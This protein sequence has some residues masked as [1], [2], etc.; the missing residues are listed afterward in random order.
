MFTRM[1][2]IGLVSDQL[3][4]WSDEHTKRTRCRPPKAPQRSCASTAAAQ[5]DLARLAHR[6]LQAVWQA[7]MQMRRRSRTR[8]QVLSVGKLSRPAAANGLRAA[9]GLWANS[10]VSRQ[11]SPEPRDSGDD[12]RDQ[13]RIAAPSRGAL[14]RPHERVAGRC[15]RLD[16]CGI[17]RRAARQYARQLD[18]RQ[19]REFVLCG[20]SR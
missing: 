18:R 20:G 19:P 12:L 17:G 2:L 7:R 6:A 16:R 1:S 5:I 4:T 8:T 15:P 9:G 11:L 10:G 3:Y 14:S 13:P